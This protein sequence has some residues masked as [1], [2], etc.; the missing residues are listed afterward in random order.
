[1]RQAAPPGIRHGHRPTQDD[2]RLGAGQV[3][4]AAGALAVRA[5]LVGDHRM[6]TEMVLV[7]SQPAGAGP[8]PLR[9]AA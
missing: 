6:L 3:A 7:H 9:A 8:V 1:M 2:V 4:L 5:G